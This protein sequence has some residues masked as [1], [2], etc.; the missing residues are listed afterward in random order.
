MDLLF[1]ANS[2]P[3]KNSPLF[4]DKTSKWILHV[5]LTL[6]VNLLAALKLLTTKQEYDTS[7]TSPVKEVITL[8]VVADCAS[9]FWQILIYYMDTPIDIIYSLDAI[10]EWY[11]IYQLKTHK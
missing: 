4:Y 11:D 10:S 6:A 3:N 8:D 5:S 2:K 1:V 9:I 7:L